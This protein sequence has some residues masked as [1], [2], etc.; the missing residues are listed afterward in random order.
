[1]KL[2]DKSLAGT[3]SIDQKFECRDN[4]PGKPFVLVQ[5]QVHFLRE[6]GAAADFLSPIIIKKFS[7]AGPRYHNESRRIVR[8]GVGIDDVPN[9]VNFRIPNEELHHYRINAGDK[10]WITWADPSAGVVG[11]GLVLTLAEW[12]DDLGVPL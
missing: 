1:M 4:V 7:A 5:L 3:G 11:W 2:Y 9:D 6:S 8:A 12:N 10:A